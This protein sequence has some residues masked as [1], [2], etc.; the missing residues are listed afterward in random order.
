MTGA[1]SFSVR[2]LRGTDRRLWHL[3]WLPV[4]AALLLTLIG[5]EAI[6]TTEP[7]Y[8]QR[9]LLFFPIA[10]AVAVVIGWIHPRWMD[11]WAVPFYIVALALLLFVLVPG[12]PEA[13]VRQ[14]KG[15]RRWINLVV[16]DFQPSELAK[17]GMI[18]VLAQWLRARE[19]I[20]KWQGLIVPAA[21]AVV[22]FVLILLEPDLGTA[23]TLVPTAA[24][25][26]LAAG[27]RR[28]HVVV[29]MLVGAVL[30]PAAY[31]FL[32]PHQRARVDALA[33]QIVGDTR[34][35]RDIGFQADR[36]MTLIG[37]G[38]VTGQ[39]EAG[40]QR[41]LET[42]ALPEEHNDMI[43]SSVACRWGLRGSI[44]LLA[45]CA[46]LSLGALAVAA[47]VRDRGGRLIAVGIAALLG[48]QVIVNIGMNIGVLPIT[49]MTLP[50]VSYGGTSLVASWIMVGMLWSVASARRAD[51]LRAAFQLQR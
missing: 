18:L 15:A 28:R 26:L 19:D 39:G 1:D 12:V 23:M 49:G 51:T 20:T 27:C 48:T 45:A 16:V 38:G 29:A 2:S 35:A 30:A 6:G 24:A 3:G 17:I 37:A 25:M 21:L 22:P 44:L 42:N 36:A 11:R 5:W 14:R 41:L 34:Y 9:Q 8:A 46:T 31:P 40:A 50:F 32:R 7:G 33:A 10:L 47:S 43:F 4:L 13:L